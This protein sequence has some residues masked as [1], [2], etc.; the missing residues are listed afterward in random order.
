MIWDPLV[1]P[2]TLLTLHFVLWINGT[3]GDR[4]FSKIVNT[5]KFFKDINI[6]QRISTIVA[7]IITE[8]KPIFENRGKH[9]IHCFTNVI[10][11]SFISKTRNIIPLRKKARMTVSRLNRIIKIDFSSRIII[12]WI[13]LEFW[14]HIRLAYFRYE[15]NLQSKQILVLRDWHIFWWYTSK[16]SSFST[17]RYLSL[18]V[19]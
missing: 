16:F 11:N 17:P 14:A 12:C 9:V 4:K 7:N 5:E 3:Y 13:R 10:Y 6:L 15:S 18:G 1:L 8:L 2:L 19:V